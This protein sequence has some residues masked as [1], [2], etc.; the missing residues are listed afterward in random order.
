MPRFCS[1]CGTQLDENVSFCPKCGTPVHQDTPPSQEKTT[2]QPAGDRQSVLS[3]AGHGKAVARTLQEPLAGLTELIASSEPGEAALCTFGAVSGA[4]VSAAGILDPLRTVLS[5]IKSFGQN[6]VG[7][8]RNK[9][10]IKLVFAV[11]IAA[12]WF[13]LL[14]LSHK[15]TDIGVLNWLTFA[16][17]GAGRSVFGWLGGLIGKTAVAAMIFSLFSGGAKSLGSGIKTLFDASNIKPVNLGPLLLGEGVAL[18]LYQFFAGSAEL[19]DTMSAISGS[20]LAVIAMGRGGGSIFHLAQSFTAKKVGGIRVAQTE[21]ANGL[22]SGAAY[23]FALGATVS[24]IPFG[25]LPVVI[26][27]VCVIAGIAFA[28]VLNNKKETAAV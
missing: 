20:V 19:T 1:K 16:Q 22:L 4:V 7:L 23:G 24:A 25:Y 26:G 17:G 3:V 8:F 18:I 2:K 15:N 10:W 28:I 11:V 27:S 14:I 6:F 21:K 13:V 12:G 9:R 5:G